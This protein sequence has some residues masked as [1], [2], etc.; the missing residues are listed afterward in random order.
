MS[1]VAAL[2][3]LTGPAPAW[4]R[5]EDPPGVIGL[6][7]SDSRSELQ[8]WNKAVVIAYVP[9]L[10]SLPAGVDP[11]SVVVARSEWVN[12]VVTAAALRP[13]FRLTLGSR[14]P[15]LSGLTRD[16][17]AH[18]IE[19]RGLKF[20]VSSD[21]GKPDAVVESQNP[22][23]QSIVEFG[24]GVTVALAA[25]DEGGMSTTTTTTTV[26]LIA[27][28]SGLGLALLILLGVLTAR[29]AGRRRRT[30]TVPESIEVKAYHGQ[31]I[32]PELTEPGP[33]TTFAGGD[34][35]TSVSVRLEPHYDPGT[36]TL[37]EGRR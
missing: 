2:V 12:Q 30:P 11:S 29:R 6:S 34:Q 10:E 17:A 5:A 26:V 35:R 1:V 33:G 28:G 31:L 15:D 24:L 32:G 9:P 4:A 27:A 18:A 13:L 16:Q 21:P 14:I 25:D 7:I 3:V 22:Q 20:S 8:K 36:F 19:T 37:E 23:P